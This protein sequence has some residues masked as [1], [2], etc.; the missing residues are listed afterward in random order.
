MYVVYFCIDLLIR[1]EHDGTHG[2]LFDEKV[3]DVRLRGME[4]YIFVYHSTL[5][6]GRLGIFC[7]SQLRQVGEDCSIV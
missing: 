2:S 6:V 7:A 5:L 3:R 1:V 4:F